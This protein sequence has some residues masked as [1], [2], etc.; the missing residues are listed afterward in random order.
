MRLRVPLIPL[1]VR[2]ERRPLVHFRPRLTLRMLLALVALFAVL[3]AA[4][5]TFVELP[6]R[7]LRFRN[8]DR[9]VTLH[10][11]LLRRATAKEQEVERAEKAREGRCRGNAQR[12]EQEAAQWPE[13]SQERA[14]HLA[15]AALWAKSAFDAS[16]AAKRAAA[17]AR[18]Y[19]A[20]VDALMACRRQSRETLTALEQMASAADGFLATEAGRDGFPLQLT[21]ARLRGESSIGRDPAAG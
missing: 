21:P 5:V 8:A 4:Y 1:V 15:I 14:S 12:E 20:D 7:R 10:I 19:Q 3:M 13:T 9:A 2:F 16:S 17:E 11:D 6:A 18:K